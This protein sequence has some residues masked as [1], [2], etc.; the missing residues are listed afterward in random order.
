MKKLEKRISECK[1][2]NFNFYYQTNIL[3]RRSGAGARYEC[4]IFF[5][6]TALLF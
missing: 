6:I 5:C 3:N 1:N 2:E 4:K